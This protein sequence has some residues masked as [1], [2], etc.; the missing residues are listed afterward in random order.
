MYR[1]DEG[2]TLT[3]SSLQASFERESRMVWRKE[4]MG[5]QLVEQREVEKS[6]KLKTGGRLQSKSTWKV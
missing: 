1:T 6:I 4:R 5:V 2:Q 3:K